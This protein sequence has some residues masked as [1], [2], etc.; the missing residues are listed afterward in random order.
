MAITSLLIS[1]EDFRYLRSLALFVCPLDS[2]RTTQT[3][4]P[5]VLRSFLRHL[6]LFSRLYALCGVDT[7]WSSAS[8]FDIYY[9]TACMARDESSYKTGYSRHSRLYLNKLASVSSVIIA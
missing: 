7:S 2:L 3:L 5:F 9:T 4:E 8:H 1:G 6:R